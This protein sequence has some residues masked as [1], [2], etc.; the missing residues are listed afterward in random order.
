MRF[1]MDGIL[2][3]NAAGRLNPDR[4]GLTSRE[5]AMQMPGA[6]QFQLVLITK[7]LIFLVPIAHQFVQSC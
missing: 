4:Y 7:V 1:P 2:L 5:R 6:W 3:H